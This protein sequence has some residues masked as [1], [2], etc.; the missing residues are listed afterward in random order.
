MP[1]G[2]AGEI[3]TL[4]AENAELRKRAE[5][6]QLAAMDT[7]L[8]QAD[9]DLP[10]AATYRRE[11]SAA[12]ARV[13]EERDTLRA[14]NER[15]VKDLAHV[16]DVDDQAIT[17]AIEAKLETEKRLGKV[18]TLLAEILGW[19]ECGKLLP[20]ARQWS[21]KAKALVDG[22]VPTEEEARGEGE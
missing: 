17:G 3:S 8:V 18:E 19:Y 12:T 7:R 9:V 15:L 10:D 5:E 14:E 22:H 1:I 13:L 20:M 21:K 11:Q 16:K 4:Q 2:Q 6:W